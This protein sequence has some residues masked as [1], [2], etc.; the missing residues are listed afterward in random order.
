M[1]SGQYLNSKDETKTYSRSNQS[2]KWSDTK[3]HIMLIEMNRQAVNE[4]VSSMTT[5]H[6]AAEEEDCFSAEI[7]RNIADNAGNANDM[8][9]DTFD[10]AFPSPSPGITVRTR[11]SRSAG[12]TT[13]IPT[14]A[15]NDDFHD[16]YNIRAL[17]ALLL[18]WPIYTAV[19]APSTSNAERIWLTSM[20][21]YL[22]DVGR[23][24]K[25]TA[26][27]QSSPYFIF[28]VSGPTLRFASCTLLSLRLPLLLTSPPLSLPL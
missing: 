23:I 11:N 27:V 19:H 25:A 21:Q 1:E 22:G 7:E 14:S 18:M 20:L 12:G 4:I 26:L 10:H 9:H 3:E 16:G 13:G 6:P 15:D 8:C 5:I 28:P 2:K 17:D 24:P